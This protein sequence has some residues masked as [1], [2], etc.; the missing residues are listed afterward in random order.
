MNNYENTGS[1]ILS[2]VFFIS[3]VVLTNFFIL[4]LTIGQMMIQY[5]AEKDKAKELSFQNSSYDEW[6]Q[7]LQDYG[8][9]VLPQE[10]C[11]GDTNLVEFIIEKDI[12]CLASKTC[13]DDA[14][15]TKIRHKL[16]DD[17]K[18]S[19]FVAFAKSNK[20]DENLDKTH[21]YYQGCLVKKCLSIIENVYFNGFILLVIIANTITLSLDKYPNYG[22]D[23]SAIIEAFSTLFTFIFFIEIVIKLIGLGVKAFFE[24]RFNIFDLF[25]V[26]TGIWGNVIELIGNGEN[27][28]QL[29]ILRTFRCFRIFKLFKV[30]DLRVLIDS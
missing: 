16:H 26:V 4:N 22:E 30:G 28:K 7:M 11:Q 10:Y 29:M 1:R 21:P 13:E 27:N 12:I 15:M 25:I 24:D 6:N 2:W 18:E 23:G 5:E 20:Q 19:L 9:K 8:N 17:L 3:C 14:E